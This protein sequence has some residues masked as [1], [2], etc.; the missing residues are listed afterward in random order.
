MSLSIQCN[1]F[2]LL[3][4]DLQQICD[5]K[6]FNVNLQSVCINIQAQFAI[7]VIAHRGTCLRQLALPLLDDL[8]LLYSTRQKFYPIL[9][10]GCVRNA[11][12]HFFNLVW[13][14]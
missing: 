7:N 14:I 10:R 6:E 1:L 11:P 8:L 2:G 12:I 13:F 4:S 3:P 5:N 9:K